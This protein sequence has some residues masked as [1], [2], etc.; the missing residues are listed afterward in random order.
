MVGF[1]QHALIVDEWNELS[2]NINELA[3]VIL[4]EWDKSTMK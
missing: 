1:D 3:V 4:D 2:L